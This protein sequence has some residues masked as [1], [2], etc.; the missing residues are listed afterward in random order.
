LKQ[1]LRLRSAASQGH[2]PQVN[3]SAEGLSIE[4]AKDMNA[5]LDCGFLPRLFGGGEFAT[6]T[7]VRPTVRT[8]AKQARK[9]QDPST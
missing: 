8:P 2:N 6:R 3:G 9:R 4:V 1:A 5:G 7:V